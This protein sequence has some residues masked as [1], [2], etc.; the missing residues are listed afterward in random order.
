M[1]SVGKAY[2]DSTV[3]HVHCT[4]K[5]NSY[6]LYVV[7]PLIVVWRYWNAWPRLRFFELLAQQI[8]SSYVLLTGNQNRNER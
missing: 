2:K 8:L 4:I 3:N 1:K 6:A 5:I 7:D